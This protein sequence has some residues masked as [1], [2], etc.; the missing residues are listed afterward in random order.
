MVSAAWRVGRTTSAAERA[1][2][3]LWQLTVHSEA[4]SAGLQT[5][6]EIR[7]PYRRQGTIT[8]TITLL[9]ED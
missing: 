1:S 4:Y 3:R 8:I 6:R 9:V 5:V 2:W 7:R